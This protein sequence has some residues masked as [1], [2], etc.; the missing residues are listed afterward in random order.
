MS[1]ISSF[2]SSSLKEIGAITWPSRDKTYK[3]TLIVIIG[4]VVGG[5]AIA[6]LDYGLLNSFRLLIEK[7]GQ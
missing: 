3:D 6:A 7:I 1:K 4:L 2:I 5:A